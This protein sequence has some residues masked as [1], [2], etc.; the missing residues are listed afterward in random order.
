VHACLCTCVCVRACVFIEILI[1][2]TIGVVFSSYT[3]VIRVKHMTGDSL[4]LNVS[5]R[6]RLQK[7]KDKDYVI[8]VKLIFPDL[9]VS[10]GHYVLLQSFQF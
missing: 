5:I 4:K 10:Y 8:P 6:Y 2:H 3:A 1:I 7:C 9:S